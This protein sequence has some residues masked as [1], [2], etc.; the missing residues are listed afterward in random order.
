MKRMTAQDWYDVADI[1]DQCVCVAEDC[2]DGGL[3]SKAAHE[4]ATQWMLKLVAKAH[5]NGARIEEKK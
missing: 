3:N 2:G 1:C 4:K 5:D